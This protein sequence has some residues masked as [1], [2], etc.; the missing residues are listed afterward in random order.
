MD[1]K[2]AEQLESSQTE[3]TSFELQQLVTAADAIERGEWKT[4]R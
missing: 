1:T 3:L 2:P 4:Q